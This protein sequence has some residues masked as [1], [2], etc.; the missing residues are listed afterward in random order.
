M[1]H[2]LPIY[3]SKKPINSESPGKNIFLKISFL[4]AEFIY[5]M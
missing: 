4:L 5:I 2:T 3:A 1:F